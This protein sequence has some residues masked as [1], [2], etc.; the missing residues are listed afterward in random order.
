MVNNYSFI[1]IRVITFSKKLEA[2]KLDTF[3][4]FSSLNAQDTQGFIY[5]RRMTGKILFMGI[6]NNT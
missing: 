5:V 6:V 2:I 1:L 3:K 4:H